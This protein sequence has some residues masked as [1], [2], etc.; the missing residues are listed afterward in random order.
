MRVQALVEKGEAVLDTYRPSPEGVIGPGQV[1]FDAF[2]GWQAQALACLH[3]VL[4]PDHPYSKR[5]AEE[6]ESPYRGH[7]QCGI[8]ILRAIRE[9]LDAGALAPTSPARDSVVIVERI[10]TRF[11]NV[12]RQLRARHDGR[13]AFDMDD[14]YDVQDLLHALLMVEFDDI[15]PEEYT[16][17]Y[18]GKTSRMDFLLKTE[19]T[20]IEAKFARPGLGAKEV[21]T[22]LIDDIARYE[23]HPDCRTLI[24]FVYDPEGRIANPRGVER[25]LSRAEGPFSVRV[26]IRPE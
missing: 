21:G 6:V 12:A 19:Q 22:Q 7:V 23:S 26:L 14:E 1:A 9:D 8:G 13:V 5:F 24:C 25:D 16:P 3:S 11:R 2:Y 4:G 17:S 20:V 15:R 10:L 18:A